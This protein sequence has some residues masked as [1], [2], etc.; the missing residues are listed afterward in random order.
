MGKTAN[1]VKA[2]DL[3]DGDFVSDVFVYRDEPFIFMHSDAQGKLVSI[4]DINEQKRGKMKRGQTG[5]LAAKLKRGQKLKG[6][7]AITE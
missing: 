1:G 6:A 4:D 7:I 5:R 3:E 2:I